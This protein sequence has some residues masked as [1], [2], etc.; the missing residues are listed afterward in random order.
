MS[1]HAAPSLL[2]LLRQVDAM[3]PNRSKA[4]DGIIGDAAHAARVSDH[5]PNTRG[6]VCAVDITHDPKGGCDA[7]RIAEALRASR[8]SRIH[9]VIWN[10]RIFSSTTQPWT[11]RTYAGE[12][13]HTEH[14]HISVRDDEAPWG[15]I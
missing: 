8:D 4:S 10:R 11:W 3:A 7:N 5:N 6:V 2:A 12:S 15:G 14:I 1:W 9:Y 13:P